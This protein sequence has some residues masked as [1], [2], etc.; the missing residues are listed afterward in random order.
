[1]ILHSRRRNG[2]IPETARNP[3]S[4]RGLNFTGRAGLKFG[5]NGETPC[6]FLL[7]GTWRANF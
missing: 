5:G 7:A 3:L 1:M 6:T 2:E 4:G